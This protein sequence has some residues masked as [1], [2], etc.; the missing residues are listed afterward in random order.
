MPRWRTM[1]EPAGTSWPSPTFTPSRWPTQSRP[2]FEL[3]PAFLWAMSVYSSFFVA[4]ALLRCRLLGRLARRPRRGWS[5]WPPRRRPRR[6]WPAFAGAFAAGLRFGRRR[7]AVASTWRGLAGFSSAVAFASDCFAS[8]AA[9]SASAAAC[10]AAAS[11]RRSR[12]VF[13]SASSLRFARRRSCLPSRTSVT[14]R[15]VSSWRWPFLTRWRAFGRYL[16]EMTFSPRSRRTTSALDRGIFH[17]RP[18]D[19]RLIAIG[20]EQHAID[21][22]ALAGLRLE[23]LDFELCPDLDAVL[24]PA[25]LDDCVHGTLRRVR[26]SRAA[27]AR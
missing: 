11:W 9:S 24:L 25:G 10:F 15:T 14:R 20:D 12:S 18:A 27:T 16:N 1:I 7:L 5:P 17:D 23:Q 2:F 3:E 13:A 19:R 21:R 8:F 4:R 22:D 26:R 6:P